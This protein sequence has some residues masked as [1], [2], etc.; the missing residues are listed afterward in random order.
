MKCEAVKPEKCEFDYYSY[1]IGV[2][3][4]SLAGIG[5]WED[6]KFVVKDYESVEYCQSVEWRWYC[7]AGHFVKATEVVEQ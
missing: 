1:P 2:F 3:E 5:D 7:P 6:G 4:E